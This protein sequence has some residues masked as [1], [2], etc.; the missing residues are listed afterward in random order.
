MNALPKET[1][2]QNFIEGK[3]ERRCGH[4]IAKVM[5]LDDPELGMLKSKKTKQAWFERKIT[6]GFFFGGVNYSIFGK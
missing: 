4:E 2:V 6:S 1:F 5:Q 3:E